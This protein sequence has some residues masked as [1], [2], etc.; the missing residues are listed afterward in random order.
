MLQKQRHRIVPSSRND[1]HCLFHYLNYQILGDTSVE[2]VAC[3]ILPRSCT[4]HY[5][6]Y[7]KA[8]YG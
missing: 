5:V 4:I 3:S 6:E 1:D 2:I 8:Y 7:Q